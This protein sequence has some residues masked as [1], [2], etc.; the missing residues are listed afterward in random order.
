[1]KKVILMQCLYISRNIGMLSFR[2]SELP[3]ANA[4]LHNLLTEKQ[5]QIEMMM[6]RITDVELFIEFESSCN[7][8]LLEATEAKFAVERQQLLLQIQGLNLQIHTGTVKFAAP[9]LIQIHLCLVTV[10]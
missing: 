4:K 7:L 1:M 3:D 5:V 6:T 9:L 8:K 10:M 2:V